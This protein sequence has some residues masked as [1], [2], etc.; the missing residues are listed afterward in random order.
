MQ[1][2]YISNRS[3]MGSGFQTLMLVILAQMFT[4]ALS[5]PNI[6]ASVSRESRYER[7]TSRNVSSDKYTKVRLGMTQNQSSS[8]SSLET[9]PVNASII[10]GYLHMKAL[11]LPIYIGHNSSAIQGVIDRYFPKPTYKDM[12]SGLRYN[13]W[14]NSTSNTLSYLTIQGNYL[15][16]APILLPDQFI[17]VFDNA[18]LEAT[19]N[20][21]STTN[22][23]PI[24]KSAMA[25][26]VSKN[27]FFNAVVSP[28][29][30]SNAVIS[31]VNMPKQPVET[32]IVGPAGILLLGSGSSLIDGV[33]I[34][35]CGLGN[36]NIALY[37]SSRV[38][39]ANVM[40][41]NGRTRGIWIIVTSYTLLHDS[42]F[43]GSGKVL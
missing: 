7:I 5:F 23:V 32:N 17:L 39:I 29:G 3:S 16:D 41:I 42:T 30:P 27:S 38:E 11:Q 4:S 36:G 35:S 33:T 2:R 25:L 8:S 6:A 1:C 21:T 18:R 26:I 12:T 43:S 31:C 34:D 15:A 13:V 19:V 40:S 24:D 22:T 20:F 28:G 14:L 37:G 9:Y 10:D